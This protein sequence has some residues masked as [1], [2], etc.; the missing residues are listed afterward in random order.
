[1]D[2]P[3]GDK[4]S[5]QMVWWCPLVCLSCMMQ[6]LCIMLSEELQKGCS[7]QVIRVL[8]RRLNLL[9]VHTNSQKTCCMLQ[10]IRML[11]GKVDLPLAHTSSGQMVW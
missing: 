10:V 6:V 4:S 2:L 3:V 9:L 1:M 8:K 11:E 5:G 7:L